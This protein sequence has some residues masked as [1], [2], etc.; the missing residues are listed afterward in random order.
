MTSTT[1]TA[2]PTTTA[3]AALST[4]KIDPAHSAAEF[5]GKTHDDLIR[6]RQVFGVPEY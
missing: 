4:W 5:K 3:T 2:A 6:Q 1:P